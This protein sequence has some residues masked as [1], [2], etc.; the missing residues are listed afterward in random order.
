MKCVSPPTFEE[1]VQATPSARLLEILGKQPVSQ[2]EKYLHWNELRHKNPPQGLSHEEWWLATKLLRKAMYKEIPHRDKEGR[3]FVYAEPDAVRQSLHRLDI[4]IGPGLRDL[5]LAK[6]PATGHQ[7]LVNS[8][9]EESIASGQLEGASTTREVA[10]EV[11]KRGKNPSD[12]SQQ[13]IVNNYAAIQFVCEVR[14]DDLTPKTILRIHEMITEDTLDNPQDAGKLRRSDDIIVAAPTGSPKYYPPKAAELKKRLNSLCRFANQRAGK[15]FL[16]PITRAIIL[17]FLLGYDHPF[18]DGNGRTARALFYW[19]LLRDGYDVAQYIPISRK[20]KLA[21]AQYAKAYLR[22]ENDE[23]D[24]TYFII[25]QLG[26]MQKAL[27]DTCAY[28][29]KKNAE[30]AEVDKAI[31]RL[32]LEKLL[33]HRQK[34]LLSRALRKPQAWFTVESHRHSHDVVYQTA[35]TD[36]LELERYG[37]LEK[38][39]QGKEFVFMPVKDI[40]RKFKKVAA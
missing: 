22:T 34:A 40:K 14:D 29:E 20:I 36:L 11:L 13:M 21:P 27:A 5:S 6:D 12:I 10:K 28:L 24:M 1:L 26:I 9:I 39:R 38:H 32:R 15:A 3:P 37:L 23:G 33:N 16:H 35:R 19:S 4:Q 7:Y 2:S 30:M 17:H 8:L 31:R 25:H 18:A